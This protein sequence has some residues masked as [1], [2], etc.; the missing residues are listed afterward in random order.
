[1]RLSTLVPL[2]LL[3]VLAAVPAGAQYLFLDTNGDGVHDSNDALAPSGPTNIDIWYVTDKN[4]D[5]TPAVCDVDAGVGLTIN[6]YTVVLHAVGGDVQWGPMQNRLPFTHA[7]ACFAT[8]ADTTDASYYHNGWGSYDIFPPGKYKV[9]TLTVNVTGGNPSLFVEP[10]LPSRPVQLT[11]FG[12]KCPARDDDNTYKLGSEWTDAD[13]IGPMLAEAGGPYRVQAG[14][15]VDLSASGSR[16]TNGHTLSYSWDFGDGTTGSGENVTHLYAV[17][18]DYTAV[19]T[20]HSGSEIATDAAQVHVVEGH[21]PIAYIDGPRSAYVGG[22]VRFDGRASVDPE[23]DPITF[24]WE[25]G[26]GITAR[27]SEATHAWTGAGTFTVRLTVSDGL[28]SDTASQPMYVKPEPHPPTA[29]AGGPY[30]GFAGRVVQ[31]DGRG[32][33]DPDG[34]PLTYAW[35][36]GDRTNGSGAITGHSYEAPGTYNVRLTVDDGYLSSSSTTTAVIAE[37]IPARVFGNQTIPVVTLGS[38][39]PLTL[40]VEPDHGTFRLD[41]VVLWPITI[42]STGTGSV[43]DIASIADAVVT[44]DLDQNGEPELTMEFSGEELALLFGSVQSSAVVTVKV[45]G[46]LYAG[47]SFGSEIR[48]L[49]QHQGQGQLARLRVSPNPFNPEAT[50]TFSTSKDGPVRAQLYDVRGRMIRTVLEYQV[51]PAGP[52]VLA[53]SARGDDGV[54]L[55]SGVYFFRLVGPDGVTTKRVAVAK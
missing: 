28:K 6:S 25:F 9:A 35:G 11:Q 19:L 26:D 36:F 31:F 45:S 23:G 48:V 54:V 1:M 43:G 20:A 39:D 37:S 14:R 8:W 5:G 34:D 29:R 22:S 47:G 53:L 21:A 33:S 40:H 55:A 2:G 50:V 24:S 41:D 18:G 30:T 16:T 44:P 12:T 52:H 49:V 51:L 3:V 4:R 7:P 10:F 27:G 32:S 13:G 15:P 17:A 42:R 38:G 46:S